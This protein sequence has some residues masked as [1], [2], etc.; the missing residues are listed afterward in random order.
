MKR[1]YLYTL[2]KTYRESLREIQRTHEAGQGGLVTSQRIT[3]VSDVLIRGLFDL[4]DPAFR[5]PIAVLALGGYGRR[6]LCPH[7]DIDILILYRDQSSRKEAEHGSMA[8]LH[9]LYDVGLEVGHAFRT[10][11]ETLG[12]RTTDFDSWAAL[13]EGRFLCGNNSM[14]NEFVERLNYAQ[15]RNKDFSFIHHV[16]EQ[17]K[18]RHDKFGRSVKLLEPNVKQS[19]GGL[20]D[21]HSLV[22]IFLSLKEYPLAAHDETGSTYR[23]LSATVIEAFHDLN[24][25]DLP[26]CKNLNTALDYLL[27]VRQ[28]LHFLSKNTHDTLDFGLQ[29]QVAYNLGYRDSGTKRAVEHFMRDYYIHSREI[30]R[31]N[32]LFTQMYSELYRPSKNSLRRIV[33]L[34]EVYTYDGL[35]V[36]ISDELPEKLRRGDQTVLRAFVFQ[37]KHGVPLDT[38]ARSFILEHANLIDNETQHSRATGEMFSALWNAQYPAMAL[39]TMHEL[40]ILERIIPEF[41]DLVAFFQHNQ[42]HYYTADE[43]TIIATEKLQSL[44]DQNSLLGDV[45]RSLPDKEPL[46]F[47]T[48]FHD[49]GKPRRVVDHEIIGADMAE[50]ILQRLH[51]MKYLDDIQFLIRHHLMMEQ[52]AF[53]RN[54]YEQETVD[55]FASRFSSQT[56]LDMLF[57]LTF[58]DLSAVNPKIW[59]DWKKQLLQELYLRTSDVLSRNMDDLQRLERYR[60]SVNRIIK[61]ISTQLPEHSVRAHIDLFDDRSYIS[62]FSD[63]EITQHIETIQ[64]NHRTGAT[65]TLHYS[66]HHAFTELTIITKDRP[67]ALSDFCGIL[68]AHDANIIDANIFTR[69]DGIIIDK[70]RV[71]DFIHGTSLSDETCV[72]I[73]QRLDDLAAGTLTNIAELVQR[74]R[75]KWRRKYSKLKTNHEVQVKFDSTP[76]HT[77]IDVFGPD[78]IGMLFV[79]T[80]TLSE[81]GLNIYFAKIASRLDGIVDSFY[82]LTDEGKRIPENQ[83][84]EIRS[85]IEKSLEPILSTE[86]DTT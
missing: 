3:E 71:V 23:S 54:I 37:S 41:G 38:R 35:S 53:R 26:Q 19:A 59:T 13:L 78:I 25:I 72:D 4:L 76:H 30:S 11:D 52:V 5:M 57:L 70:F 21:I 50:E 6:E 86:E 55:E 32:E 10:F 18:R 8:F 61:K 65:V 80:R 22:W 82:V 42:Y 15:S 75:R 83:F 33:Q 1:A 17:Q 81:L 63:K 9:L 77:I 62:S 69:Y 34:D 16:I 47:A 2:Q 68:T 64:Q 12:L 48:L 14:Y 7:S 67:Y 31:F 29:E 28:Q 84:P 73:K 46:Y 43:H 44:S 27:R 56:Q 45:F 49:I 24:K 85:R 66:H 36:G 20:R 39:R 60:T 79:I 51:C 74:Q 40:G 58:A